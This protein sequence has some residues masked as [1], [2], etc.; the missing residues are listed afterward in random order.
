MTVACRIV[1]REALARSVGRTGVG[2]FAA[3]GVCH[4]VMVARFPCFRGSFSVTFEDQER[5]MPTTLRR[6]GLRVAATAFLLGAW[7]ASDAG[8]AAMSTQS[9]N[10]YMDYSTSGTVDSAGI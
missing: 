8:A 5:R 2:R 1:R 10:S 9:L 3:A 6:T 4:R 7:S